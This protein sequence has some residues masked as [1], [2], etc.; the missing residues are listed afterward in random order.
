[1]SANTKKWVNRGGLVGMIVGVILIVVAGG[2]VSAATNTVGIVAGIAGTV[3]V[4]IREL[5]N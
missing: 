3:A 5:L 1:M 4:L 2:D